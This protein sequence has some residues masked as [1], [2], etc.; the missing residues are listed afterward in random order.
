MSW[1]QPGLPN[2]P[3]TIQGL[4][5]KVA[6]LERRIMRMEAT[7]TVIQDGAVSGSQV[8]PGSITGTHIAPGSITTG[9]IQAGQ[10]TAELIAA[11]AI[12]AGHIQ[13]SSI[14]SSHI[15]AN[16][17]VAADIA[18][19]TITSN[20]IATNTITANNIATG[21]ITAVQIAANT[22]TGDRIVSDTIT[23][24]EISSTT[25]Q[26]LWTESA[27]I[28][29][30]TIRGGRFVT[31]TTD[32]G[33]RV[34]IDATGLRG[35]SSAG[36]KTFEISSGTGVYIQAD[37]N[38]VVPTASLN[39]LIGSRNLLRNPSFEDTT[40]ALDG[41]AAYN[42]N[43]TPPATLD[44]LANSG[45]TKDGSNIARLTNGSDT[46]GEMGVSTIF[47]NWPSVEAG[48][49]Y[50]LSVYGRAAGS[51][52]QFR[53]HIHWLDASNTIIGTGTTGALVSGV[54]GSWERAKVSGTAPAGA[55]R[56]TCYAWVV[57]PGAGYVFYFDA[58][59]FEEGDVA[60]AYAP[61]VAA[62]VPGGVQGAWLGG[63]MPFA[64]GGNRVTNSGAE[65]DIAQGGWY[66]NSA[67][68]TVARTTEQ[69][70]HGQYSFKV[71]TT[72]G[73]GP[74][75]APY[76]WSISPNTYPPNDPTKGAREAIAVRPSTRYVASAYFYRPAATTSA[77]T[78]WLGR[79]EYDAAGSYVTNSYIDKNLGTIPADTWTRLTWDF[80]TGS[81]ARY[82]DIGA[83]ANGLTGAGLVFYVDS[84]QVEEGAVPTNY[85]PAPDEI[86]YGSIRSLFIGAGEIKANNIEAGAI[87][88]QHIQVTALGGRNLLTNAGFKYWPTSGTDSAGRTNPGFVSALHPGY[89][90]SY[91]NG[92]TNGGTVAWS[93]VAN[94]GPDSTRPSWRLQITGT[95]TQNKGFQ[96]QAVGVNYKLKPNTWYTFS[97]WCKGNVQPNLSVSNGNRVNGVWR[98]NPTISSTVWQRYIYSFQMNATGGPATL[99]GITQTDYMYV[100][101]EITPNGVFNH[102][103]D[104]Q[105]ADWQL[106]ESEGVTTWGPRADEILPGSLGPTQITP[107]GITTTE[108]ATN[109]ITANNI[110]TDAIQARHVSAG[111]IT[112][113]KISVG[114]STDNRVV[115]GD[116]EDNNGEL[117]LPAAW[118]AGEGNGFV[119]GATTSSSVPSGKWGLAIPSGNNS[120][121]SR[122]IP[123]LPGTQ[124]RVR[125]ILRHDNATNSTYF[126]INEAT[127]DVAADYI[128]L[129]NRNSYTELIAPASTISTTNTV[130][131]VTYTVP[132]GVKYVSVSFYNWTT[133][134]VGS[135]ATA[136]PFL[137]VDAVRM[138]PLVTGTLI[139]PLSITAP[140]IA[141]STITADKLNVGVG[142]ANLLVNSSFEDPTS[143]IEG[144]GI[145]GGIAAGYFQTQTAGL[146]APGS[147]GTTA[148]VISPNNAA[149]AAYFGQGWIPMPPNTKVTFSFWVRSNGATNRIAGLML[150][151]RKQDNT[152][153]ANVFSAGD[154]PISAT[155]QRRIC[156]VTTPVDCKDVFAY[157]HLAGS[158]TGEQI[159]VDDV[160]LEMG[161]VA[162]AWSQ[163][164]SPTVIDGTSVTG[165]LIRTA[166]TGART[167]MDSAGLRIIDS[168]GNT[169]LAAVAGK[170]VTGGAISGARVEFGTTGMT[171][172]DSSNNAVSRV[173]AG[174][175]GIDMLAGSSSAIPGERLARWLNSAGT[176]AL[177]TIG[178]FD[179]SGGHVALTSRAHNNGPS[180]AYTSIQMYARGPSDENW[181]SL[182]I[183]YDS[184]AGNRRIKTA[185]GSQSRT[186]L[187]D[188]GGS[189]FV[190]VNTNIG[191]G[192]I[193]RIGSTAPTVSV[194]AGWGSYSITPPPNFSSVFSVQ[195][196]I[197][198]PTGA[199]IISSHLMGYSTTSLTI[200]INSSVAQSV[201][202]MV[203]Y[204]GS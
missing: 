147:R 194:G 160:Q 162:T 71:T 186:I 32:T 10:I 62:A 7:R 100:M 96:S 130:Y 142:S 48:K 144:W 24:R 13:A 69:S 45:N 102:N 202:I 97:V 50:T 47:G 121:S 95:I 83:F 155:W 4:N 21:T 109:T 64:G 65:A 146:V 153:N 63:A 34:D 114:A 128:S 152:S 25:L 159:I 161:D 53:V 59:Q 70:A 92:G 85:S 192:P 141:A 115:N 57:V 181:G 124:Y 126:R 185:V 132:A 168:S 84:F 72:A 122:K 200:A 49:T 199:S 140:H 11:G 136:S 110:A 171:V 1:I 113:S 58:F 94:G 51:G 60:T 179:S 61:P 129:L 117:T 31:S 26:A 28:T 123:V 91:D 36:V 52:A 167:E 175:G 111:S 35:Y 105:V 163:Y 9:H 169:A 173:R 184:G 81:T 75:N 41:W 177:G 12:N 42:N 183:E 6:G 138:E 108:I 107:N 135:G 93:R 189:D 18:A 89:F 16:T 3:G 38:S 78:F 76:V 197:S 40:S 14:N 151:S 67:A 125:A 79:D 120:V 99:N 104:I 195:Y 203:F 17:I 29:G 33:S 196:S 77:A 137:H 139:T 19:N 131:E 74:T 86:L 150:S 170:L 178:T 87:N 66:A 30:G 103:V 98:S 20:E 180:A 101:P 118:Y 148:L 193:R 145:G 157:V 166:V 39:G 154:T 23:S 190:Q 133:V 68:N 80:T 73:A 156:T 134:A 188:G 2:S 191:E 174:G 22:I 90:Q 55:V 127:S 56:A 165:A 43:L 116:F 37:P 44:I 119:Y 149:G 88:A 187:N 8:A 27:L 164:I 15:Q 176:L 143:P 5:V 204:Y 201:Q 106:E 112:A 198:T 46:T 182:G 54:S 82:I 158:S 172:F